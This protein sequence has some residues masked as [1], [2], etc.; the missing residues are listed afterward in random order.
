MARA[1]RK[2]AVKSSGKAEPRTFALHW[3]SG[4][5]EE[6][7]RIETPYHVPA[8][9]LLTFTAGDH[10]GHRQVRLCHYDHRGRFQRSPL[11]LGEEDL[12]RLRQALQSAPRLRRLLAK[13]VR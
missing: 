9:Q 10:A 13:L 4:I 8:I 11:I 1:V 2:K 6:E 5:I 12:P 3:G 7:V